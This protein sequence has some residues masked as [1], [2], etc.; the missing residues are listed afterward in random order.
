MFPY[1]IKEVQ[2][3]INNTCNLSCKDCLSFNNFD[4]QGYYKWSQYEKQNRKWSEL[5][6]P[7]RVSILGGEPFLN[8]DLINWI[9]G[10]RDAWGDETLITVTTNGTLLKYSKQKQIWKKMIDLGIVMEITT[11]CENHYQEA[12]KATLDFYKEETIDFETENFF[13]SNNG[14]YDKIA[15]I[16][17]KSRVLLATIERSF[18]FEN[19]NISKIENNTIF[20]YKNDPLKAH[21]ICDIRECHYIV[22]GKLYKCVVV[23]TWKELHKKISIDQDSV[24]ELNQYNGCDPFDEKSKILN[25][26]RDISS[27]ISQCAVCTVNRIK[28]KAL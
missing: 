3:Y 4:L 18:D 16:N 12:W 1:P 6:S 13:N 26:L 20:F 23:A 19:R 9:I 21:D 27:P 7:S 22:E 14:L 10:I 5:I 15:F 8:P 17:K 2:Y 24:T 28:S 11:H 25:F